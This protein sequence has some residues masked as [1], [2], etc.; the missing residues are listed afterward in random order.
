MEL[1]NELIE[2]PIVKKLVGFFL[3]IAA[4]TL[5]QQLYNAVDAF[6]VGKFVGTAAL[7]AVGG[8]PAILSNLIIGFFVALT[9]GAAVVI[10]QLFGAQEYERVSTAM[11]VSYRLCMVLGLGMGALVCLFSPQLLTLLKTPADTFDQALLYQ[12]IYFLGAVFL[13]LFNMGSGILRSI[14]D[15]RFPFLCLF[16]G[17]GL[18]IVLDV[19]FVILFA[20]GVAGVAV[21]TVV[22]QAVAA[23]LVTGKLLT[24]KGPFRLRLRG[25]GD[26]GLL[27]QMLRIGIPSGVQSSMY[28]LSNLLLQVGVNTLGTVVVASWAMSGKVDGAFWAITSAFGTALTTFVGQ[29]Y[30]AGKL[31]RIRECSKKSLLLMTGM[32]VGVSGVLVLMARPLLHLLTNDGAVIDTTWY[33]ILLFVPFYLI[34][35][36]IEVFSGVLRGVGDVLTPSLIL[37]GGICGFRIL[38]LFTA[39]QLWPTLLTLCICYPLSWVVTDI[40]IY[41]YFRH[42]PV[43][44]KAVRVIDSDYD[45]TAR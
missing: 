42:S 11:G 18:N 9:G 30:G 14:G 28:G 45:H 35:V 29:N 16:V 7:A 43:M 24:L 26:K 44:T 34:W 8:S 21:A 10:A 22:S 12:R 4:G 36:P 25:K 32:T 40:A 33:I 20:W 5:F 19:V 38:W 6:V 13:L 41:L 1:R 37:A 17:C 39:F 2:G 27:K 15:A 31:D 3:P 23:L